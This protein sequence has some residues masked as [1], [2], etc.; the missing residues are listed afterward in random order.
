MK[1]YPQSLEAKILALMDE[2][3]AMGLLE[4]RSAAMV[5]KYARG[6]RRYLES[7]N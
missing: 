1:E 4:E 5:R 6:I 2:P 7:V 3:F